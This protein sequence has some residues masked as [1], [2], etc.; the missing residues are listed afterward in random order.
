[1]LRKEEFTAANLDDAMQIAVSKFN[2][3]ED[4]I[5]VT[6]LEENE[7]DMLVE[8]LVD[9]NLMLEGK[10]YIESILSEFNIDYKLESK[11]N[12]DET[13]IFYNIVTSENSLLIGFKGRTLD[14]LQNLV[15]DLLRSYKGSHLIVT[16]D[17]GGYREK[18]KSQLEIVATKTAK[19][20]ARTK[21]EVKLDPMNSFERRIIHAKLSD[22]RDV[23]TESEGSGE[24]RAIVIKPKK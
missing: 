23:V 7:N 8:A 1:M 12:P 24:S 15:R 4:K 2:I 5:F 11:T 21:I 16:I 19:E 20:V 10:R 18:R 6:V 13:E 14:A 9:I 3:S 17:I 22:W